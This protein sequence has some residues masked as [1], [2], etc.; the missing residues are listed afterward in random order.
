MKGW[1]ILAKHINLKSFVE[2][3]DSK[4]DDLIKSF[5]KL[6]D[7]GFSYEK[8]KGMSE[9]EI[10]DF[11]LLSKQLIPFLE[12][13]Q[14]NGYFIGYA[15]MAGI[16]EEF[17]IL[18]FS[19]TIV[20]N[21]ELK[22]K[23]P[24]GGF[25]SI[26]DQLIRHRFLLKLLEKD[27]IVCTFVNEINK[28][29][30]LDEENELKEINPS[31]LSEMI[32]LNCIFENELSAIN[33]SKL[34]ISP[35]SQ[36]DEFSEHI[37]F[38]TD[39]QKKVRK[40]ILETKYEK[41]CL[42]GGPGTGKSMLLLDL[43]KEYKLQKYK[44]IIIFCASMKD[45]KLI[46][47]KIG[48]N[49]IPVKNMNSINFDEIDIILIDEAQRLYK[50]QYENLLE[51]KDKI[52]VFSTD[53]QQT[54]HREEKLLDV[55]K[56]LENNSEVLTKKLKNKIRTNVQMASFIRKFLDLTVRKVQP[57][58]YDKV[59]VVYFDNKETASD[60]I[61][62][63]C[64]LESYVSIELTEYITKSSGVTK[65]KN[66]Y[67]KSKSSHSVIGREYNKVLIPI[68]EHF[69]YKEGKLTSTYNEYYP[70]D[71]T[72]CVF[73]ALTRVKDEL[74]LVVINNPKLYIKIQKIL[75]WKNDK[76][77]EN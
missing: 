15:V 1:I 13:S 24:S 52:V 39:E 17:D 45:Y 30:F 60:Y 63:M 40:D 23:I 73:E 56:N 42:V 50:Y 34:L 22:H 64:E 37:Y 31:E 36:P 54:L 69:I 10:E 49:I 68:D 76:L 71:E 67:E 32:P 8:Q 6:E 43:A 18:R 53:H 11:A 33:L 3:F 4:D 12:F 61:E 65:R 28:I 25:E 9:M 46:S 20:L 5:V 57:Y 47:D 19:K 72:S 44:V 51:L 55:E 26:R 75:S 29:Y 16:R 14:M 21:I 74:L 70:Y 2:I 66:I 35:Y 58:D 41:I 62:N 38:L 48:I 59:N 7:S 77:S 27:V